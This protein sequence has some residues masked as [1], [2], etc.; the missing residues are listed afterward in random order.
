[1]GKR[2]LELRPWLSQNRS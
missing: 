1:M 2:I